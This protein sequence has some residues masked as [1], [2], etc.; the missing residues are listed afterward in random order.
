MR[1]FIIA[2]LAAVTLAGCATAAQRQT[3]TIK[4]VVHAAVAANKECIVALRSKPE[5]A[6]LLPH[7]I[8]LENKGQPTMAQLGDDHYATKEEAKLLAA[9][10]DETDNC[11]RPNIEKITSVAPS[12]GLILTD[13][14]I[15]SDDLALQV[16]KHEITWGQASHKMQAGNNAAQKK[17]V[18]A[19]QELD[20]ELA[21]S[22][23]AELAQRQQALDALA[24][25][26]QQQQMINAFNRPITTNCSQMGRFTNCT[27][28]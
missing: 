9:F 27:T 12:V 2:I 18:A 11:K 1:G 22:N 6:P 23:Q 16:I 10:H 3:S 17:I 24:Q 19:F 4:T 20:R 7:L 5:Y 28:Y 8:P 21:A 14:V 26:S 13:V 25:W 15:D